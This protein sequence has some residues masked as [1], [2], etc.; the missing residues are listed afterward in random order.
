MSETY[1]L[2]PYLVITDNARTWGYRIS[3]TYPKL[4]ANEIV[5]RLNLE[6]PK[7]YFE[8]P[9]LQAKIALPKI[10]A[11][12]IEAETISEIEEHIKQGLGVNVNL[13]LL[14]ESEE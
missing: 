14:E 6:I 4:E 12:K 7:V 13:T 2:Q 10:E 5:I 11:Q 9:T 3:K 8:K 1:T